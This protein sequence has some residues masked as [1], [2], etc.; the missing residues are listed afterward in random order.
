MYYLTIT[1]LNYVAI[2]VKTALDSKFRRKNNETQGHA[3]SYL[4]EKNFEQSVIIKIN[5]DLKKLL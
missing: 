3:F 4:I 2:Y 1:P 5:T